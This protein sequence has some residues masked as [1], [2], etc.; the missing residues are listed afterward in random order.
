MLAS[1]IAAFVLGVWAGFMGCM[2]F[3]AWVENLSYNWHN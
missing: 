2:V 3:V 1:G